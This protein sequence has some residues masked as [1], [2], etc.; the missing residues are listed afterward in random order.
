MRN[1]RA[2][3]FMTLLAPFAARAADFAIPTAF[4]SVAQ[5]ASEA[6]AT[7]SWKISLIPLV[8]SQGLDASSSWGMRELN[9]VLAD[10][11][12]YSIR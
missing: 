2:L 1:F 10:R 9:P 8:A 4:P 5:A 11:N 3:A 6:H 7:R 12:G